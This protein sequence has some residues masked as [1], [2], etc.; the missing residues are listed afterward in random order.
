MKMSRENRLSLLLEIIVH[1]YNQRSKR[2]QLQI[3]TISN[4]ANVVAI[5]NVTYSLKHEKVKIVLL[6]TSLVFY[7]NSTLGYHAVTRTITNPMGIKVMIS[8]IARCL[9][10]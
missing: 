7:A 3:Q 6:D 5:E 9:S 10:P 2:K 8:R 1:I 4:L